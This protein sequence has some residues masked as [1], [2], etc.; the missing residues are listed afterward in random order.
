MM[1]SNSRI[2]TSRKRTFEW[3]LLLFALLML[4]LR[5]L[6]GPPSAA[7][8]ARPTELLAIDD[9]GEPV[10]R[11]RLFRLNMVFVASVGDNNKGSGHAPFLQ[12]CR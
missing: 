6:R 8:A 2:C 12:S 3:S 11:F 5:Q 9:P 10:A 4:R 1:R 7:A